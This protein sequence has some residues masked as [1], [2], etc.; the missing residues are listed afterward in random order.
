MSRTKARTV[1]DGSDSL[2][3]SDK[4]MIILVRPRL[5]STKTW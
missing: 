4:G 2:F 5:G 3:I 1:E